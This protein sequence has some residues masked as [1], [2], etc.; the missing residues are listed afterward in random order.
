MNKVELPEYTDG[1]FELYEIVTDENDDFA[2]E[3]IINKNMKIWY[4]EI[5]IFDQTRA[6][7]E[8]A[9]IQVTKKIRI[10]RYEEINSKCIITINGVQHQV[11]NATHITNKNG[12]KE[13]EITLKTPEK[14]YEVTAGD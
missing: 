9:A 8:Q 5:S 6:A 3:K 7:L 10:P 1:R 4:K 14:T 2:T 11:Y 13:T 12:Y